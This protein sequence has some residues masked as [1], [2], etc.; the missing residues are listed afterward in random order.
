MTAKRFNPRLTFARLEKQAQ[1]FDVIIQRKGKG[2]E[3]WTKGTDHTTGYAD[4]L[5]EASEDMQ[6][7]FFK[8]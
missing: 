3:Y 5:Q 6:A 7:N 1:V 4:T 8:I 2:Y